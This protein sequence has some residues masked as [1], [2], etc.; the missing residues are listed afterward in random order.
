MED[1]QSHKPSGSVRQTPPS[2]PAWA[3]GGTGD[4]RSRGRYRRQCDPKKSGR[5]PSSS[6]TGQKRPT[7]RL[8]PRARPQQRGN[9]GIVIEARSYRMGVT[10]EV[11]GWQHTPGCDAMCS[12]VVKRGD[13]VCHRERRRDQHQEGAEHQGVCLSWRPTWSRGFTRWSL[14]S[15]RSPAAVSE[16]WYLHGPPGGVAIVVRRLLLEERIQVSS[17]MYKGPR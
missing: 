16:L 13:H 2:D 11:S 5:S 3:D 7:P 10:Q 1:W 12:A 6:G 17:A 15:T 4:R 8:E 14:P 9:T